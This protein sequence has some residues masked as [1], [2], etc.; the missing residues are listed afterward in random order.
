MEPLQW[1][2]LPEAPGRLSVEG[3]GLAYKLTPSVFPDLDSSSLW[4]GHCVCVGSPSPMLKGAGWS[5]EQNLTPQRE[6]SGF[7]LFVFGSG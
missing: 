2:V 3:F 5:E 4:W 1:R 7:G 6:A